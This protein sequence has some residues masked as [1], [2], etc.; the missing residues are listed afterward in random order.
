MIN[1]LDNQVQLLGIF[2]EKG[3]KSKSGRDGVHPP[4][5]CIN[6]GFTGRQV[7]FVSCLDETIR[8]IVVRSGKYWTGSTDEFEAL[9]RRRTSTSSPL[10]V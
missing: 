1:R 5:S 4:G 10:D 6:G 8:R 2:R 7:A 3:G 9:M